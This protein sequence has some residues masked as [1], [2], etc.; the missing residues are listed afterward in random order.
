MG[1]LLHSSKAALVNDAIFFS[2]MIARII[3]PIS[4][5]F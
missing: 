4:L 1:L 3:N 5:A 2:L